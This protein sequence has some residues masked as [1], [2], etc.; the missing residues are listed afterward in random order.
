MGHGECEHD[1]WQSLREK[2]EIVLEYGA[3]YGIIQIRGSA[4]LALLRTSR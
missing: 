4:Y 2:N 3:L 1:T